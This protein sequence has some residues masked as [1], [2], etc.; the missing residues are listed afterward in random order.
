MTCMIMFELLPDKT[1]QSLKNSR[2]W[3]DL[4]QAK[5]SSDYTF[6]DMYPAPQPLQWNHLIDSLIAAFF[7]NAIQPNKYLQVWWGVQQTKNEP[8]AAYVPWVIDLVEH[9]TGHSVQMWGKEDCETMCDLF[10]K[11][12]WDLEAV[13]MVH[14][15]SREMPLSNLSKEQL[16][17]MA[18]HLDQNHGPSGRSLTGRFPPRRQWLI[19]CKALYDDWWSGAR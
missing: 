1:K 17:E 5:H 6:I 13:Y 11:G 18:R 12:L 10:D 19:S 16:A 9:V 2:W 15:F 3:T 7:L 4:L 14:Y 8:F